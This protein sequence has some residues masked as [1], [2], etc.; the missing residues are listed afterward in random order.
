MLALRAFT[1]S[2]SIY[3]GLYE[4][5]T[6]VQESKESDDKICG[7]TI[8]GTLRFC[9]MLYVPRNAPDMHHIN[10]SI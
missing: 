3:V 8:S 1:L 6:C 4:K 7:W 9:T 5:L 2:I 10:L